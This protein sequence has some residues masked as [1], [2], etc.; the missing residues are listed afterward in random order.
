[1]HFYQTNLDN[2]NLS[3]NKVVS[4]QLGFHIPCSYQMQLNKF[5]G[6]PRLPDINITLENQWNDL[7]I[8]YKIVSDLSPE[9]SKKNEEKDYLIDTIKFYSKYRGDEIKEF[10][11]KQLKIIDDQK[12]FILNKPTW[13][14]KVIDEGIKLGIDLRK[15]IKQETF[16]K[17]KQ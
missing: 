2:C 17:E 16:R 14:I 1:M 8:E 11:D 3:E 12:K 6:F 9:K 13:M 4:S 7:C 10:V 5:N 15:K